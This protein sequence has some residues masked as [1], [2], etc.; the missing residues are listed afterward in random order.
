MTRTLKAL[1]CT[2]TLTAC[3]MTLAPTAFSAPAVSSDPPAL[4]PAVPVPPK[5]GKNALAAMPARNR[6]APRLTNRR[7]LLSRKAMGFRGARYRFGAA[8]S[9]AT[10]CS[11]L[12]MQ[13]YRS[14]GIK[15][16]HSSRGQYG[17][18]KSVSKGNLLPGDLVFFS[19]GRGISH[20]GMYI[21]NG[22]MIHAANPR[23]G[24]RIDSISGSRSMRYVGARR[25]LPEGAAPP[26]ITQDVVAQAENPAEVIAAM[27]GTARVLD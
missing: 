24:V 15:L 5:A 23:R 19:R 27:N 25:L 13:L 4:P 17:Y 2:L 26:Q 7:A 6:P 20:V 22:K 11:G 14:I 18:G 1:F 12:T 9:R 10:D 8:S 21:G 16:P 3:C